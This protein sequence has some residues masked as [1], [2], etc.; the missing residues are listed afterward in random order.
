MFRVIGK[1]RVLIVPV[2]FFALAISAG[3]GSTSRP[4]QAIPASWKSTPGLTTP[5]YDDDVQAT[6]DPPVG[7][8]A[9]PLKVKSDSVH[10]TWVSPTG[11]TAY[12]VIQ[13]TLPLPVGLN[14]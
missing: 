9:K 7:W 14:L 12:G 4:P 8:I 5:V 13:F 2:A 3:C 1:C 11:L 6:C 10:Q